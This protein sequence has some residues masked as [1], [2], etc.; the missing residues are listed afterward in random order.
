MK[1]IS[2]AANH[3]HFLADAIKP[4]RTKQL[5]FFD[6]FR[7]GLGFFIATLLCLLIIAA[8][9]WGFMMAFHLH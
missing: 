8:I 1:T 4:T 2:A 6:G 9:T 3:D 5:S 7:F